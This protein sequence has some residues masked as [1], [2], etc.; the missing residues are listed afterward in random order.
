M[1]DTL[2]P[3]AA[4]APHFAPTEIEAAAIKSRFQLSYH[5]PYCADADKLVGF[6]GKRVLEVGGSLPAGFVRDYLGA[7]QWTAVEELGYWRTVDGVEKLADSPL[8]HP[9]DARLEEATADLLDQDYVLLDGGIEQAPEALHGRFDLAFSIACFEHISRLP[10][11]LER[12]HRTLKPG[13]KLFALF[14]PIWS[15]HDGHHLPGI[16]DAT[17]RHFNFGRSP[18]P[19]WGHLM[20]SPSELYRFLL[21]HTDAAAAEEMV[22][23]VYHAPHINRL[24]AEDYVRYFKLSPF[25]IERCQPTFPT[26]LSAEAQSMLE[27]RHPGHRLFSNNGFLAILEKTA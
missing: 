18:I 13:G 17:G 10:K 9:A 24:F 22:Y 19:P 16:T 26:P 12:I 21:D 1:L 3:P 5:V 14:S 20:A 11:A 8:Q 23:Y 15:A 6:R 4:T 2:P 25:R 27:A 7:A